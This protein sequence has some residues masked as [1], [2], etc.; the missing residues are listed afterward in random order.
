MILAL[1]GTLGLLVQANAP[2]TTTAPKA[3]PIRVWLA[4]S[5]V[6]VSLRDA[7]YLTVLQV[8]PV[9]RIRVLFPLRPDEPAAVP[10]GPTFEVRAPMD[11]DGAIGTIVAA[12]SRWPFQAAGLR[13]ASTWDYDGALLFQPTAGDP[14]AALLDIVDRM[15]D[16][17]PYEFD[18]T[19]Y[20]PGRTLAPRGC[21][22]CVRSHAPDDVEQQAN[23]VIDQSNTVDCSSAV[24]INSFCG[25]MD[26]R[27][28]NTY[29]YNEVAPASEPVYVPYYVPVFIPRRRGMAPPPPP[30]QPGR[31]SV[32]AL[33]RVR[34]VV[35][36]PEPRRLPVMRVRQPRQR[37]TP[38]E[39]RPRPEVDGGSAPPP[40]VPRAATSS[41]VPAPSAPAVRRHVV[42]VSADMPVGAPVSSR[43]DRVEG[44]RSGARVS[45][46]PAG[47][48][49]VPMMRPR[50]VVPSSAM[51]RAIRD[52]PR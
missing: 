3:A 17:R 50:A 18:V 42:Q 45:E 13:T 47:T 37:Y 44:P 52:R 25:V 26:N 21:L 34:G 16:G 31:A 5:T 22:G 23:V 4:D 12:R 28:T 27:V 43:P 9:G 29:V 38:I 35:V 51:L 39:T 24:L 19:M 8:D 33:R 49:S 36:P 7:G 6:Y 11:G 10:G 15:A 40:A 2:A 30:P 14:L 32:I 1:A 46:R 20:R 41:V 48:V